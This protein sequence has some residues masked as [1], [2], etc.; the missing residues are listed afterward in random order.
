MPS[1][2]HWVY[3]ATPGSPRFDNHAYAF[4]RDAVRRRAIDT[5][6]DVDVDLVLARLNGLPGNFRQAIPLLREIAI[7]YGF[8]FAKRLRKFRLPKRL[9]RAKN[10]IYNWVKGI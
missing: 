8:P 10:P 5:L 4:F 9:R 3:M 1:R 7:E 2:T 6:L